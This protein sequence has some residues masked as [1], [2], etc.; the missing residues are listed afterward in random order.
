MLIKKYKKIGDLVFIKI[1]SNI[2]V[3]NSVCDYADYNY[4]GRKCEIRKSCILVNKHSYYNKYPYWIPK[5]HLTQKYKKYEN[6]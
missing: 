4:I 5:G 6:K 1:P 3:C 2:G